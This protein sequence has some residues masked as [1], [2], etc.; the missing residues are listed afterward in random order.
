MEQKISIQAGLSKLS[1]LRSAVS[2]FVG[3]ALEETDKGRVILAID[4][5]VSNVIVHGYNNDDTKMIE[6]EMKSDPGFFTFI[7]SDRAGEYNPL[8]TVSPDIDQYHDEGHCGGLGI[9][10]YRRIMKVQYERD[11]NGGNRLILI[12]EIKK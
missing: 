11:S 3:T 2:D 8:E 6:I 5:A 12:K 7:I 9:D 1:F 10:I 4:E